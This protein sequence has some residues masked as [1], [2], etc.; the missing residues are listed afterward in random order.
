MCQRL[1]NVLNVGPFALKE[2]LSYAQVQHKK[3]LTE[4]SYMYVALEMSTDS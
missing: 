1:V 2:H 3:L 4:R